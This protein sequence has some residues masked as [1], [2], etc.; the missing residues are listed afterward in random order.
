MELYTGKFKVFKPFGGI[1]E[2]CKTYC[3][4]VANTTELPKYCD[5]WK[6]AFSDN[7]LSHGK[8][9]IINGTHIAE[10]IDIKEHDSYGSC[11]GTQNA[12]GS[13]SFLA[14]WYNGGAGFN[15]V[16][17]EIANQHMTKE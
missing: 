2:W 9:I 10:M 15:E 3:R 17:E 12:D 11:S 1:E 5:T 6:E 7:D 13:I 16:I 8:Y 4:D 14:H